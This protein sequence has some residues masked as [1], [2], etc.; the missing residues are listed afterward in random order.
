MVELKPAQSPLHPVAD[1]SVRWNDTTNLSSATTWSP[2]LVL[3]A[4]DDMTL[5]PSHRAN[6]FFRKTS[7]CLF[8]WISGGMVANQ[9]QPVLW[10]LAFCLTAWM[11]CKRWVCGCGFTS[12]S[13]WVCWGPAVSW[14][15]P[16]IEDTTVL[17]MGSLWKHRV[18]MVTHTDFN[19]K[20]LCKELGTWAQIAIIHFFLALK[21]VQERITKGW[22]LK[23]QI[24]TENV[25]HLSLVIYFPSLFSCVCRNYLYIP[26]TIN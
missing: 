20:V 16:L 12:G 10:L 11:K 15:F 21:V 22:K 3:Q 8:T 2:A 4:S 23:K 6:C 1:T 14:C 7:Q 25:I 24:T 26:T 9:S 17:L 13:L 5:Q 19:I 18:T